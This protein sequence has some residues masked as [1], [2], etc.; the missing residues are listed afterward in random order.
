MVS[1][2]QAVLKIVRNGGTRTPKQIK[3]QWKYISK[4]DDIE[5]KRPESAHGATLAQGQWNEASRQWA[6]ATGRYAAGQQAPSNIDMTTHIVVSFPPG[7]NANNAEEAGREWAERMF[8]PLDHEDEMD[9]AALEPTNGQHAAPQNYNYITAF[10]TDREH[11]HLHVVVNRRGSDGGWLKISRRHPVM[12]YDNMRQQLVAAAANHNIALEAT[13]REERGI[14]DPAPT[15]AELRRRARVPIPIF[16]RD[17]TNRSVNDDSEGNLSYA[18]D[19]VVD[20]RDF[21][22]SEGDASVLSFGGSGG[23]GGNGGGAGGGA[24]SM[25]EDGSSSDGNGGA[26]QRRAAG[27]GAGGSGIAAGTAQGIPTE[28]TIQIG[29]NNADIQVDEEDDENNRKPAAKTPEDLEAARRHQP[30][31]VNIDEQFGD[32]GYFTGDDDYPE[33]AARMPQYIR[34]ATQDKQSEI[35]RRQARHEQ[36][37]ADA[38]RWRAE[39]ARPLNDNAA[40]DADG[41]EVSSGHGQAVETLGD[42]GAESGEAT[43]K[44]KSG[45]ALDLPNLMDVDNRQ[46]MF[47]REAQKLEQEMLKQGREQFEEELDQQQQDEDLRARESEQ[48]S[49][50]ALYASLEDLEQEAMQEML[51]L[52]A[53]LAAQSEQAGKDDAATRKRKGGY[54]LVGTGIA[55]A[56]D[57]RDQTAKLPQEQEAEDDYFAP[58]N[59]LPQEATGTASGHTQA[60]IETT[61]TQAGERDTTAGK[62]EGSAAEEG[63]LTAPADVGQE[64]LSPEAERERLTNIEE[65]LN[66]LKQELAAYEPDLDQ[67]QAHLGE[68]ARTMEQH[69]REHRDWEIKELEKEIA[70]LEAQEAQLIKEMAEQHPEQS[71]QQLEAL[72]FDDNLEQTAKLPQEQ[73]AEE[74]YLANVT[75]LPRHIRDAMIAEQAGIVQRPQGATGTA[76]GHGADASQTASGHT[77]AVIKTTE[78][79][80][81]ERDTTAGKRK[82]S[83][84]E[85]GLVAAPAD[86][87]Q[88]QLS[89]DSEQERLSDIEQ[90]LNALKEELAGYESELDQHQAHLGEIAQTMEQQRRE[91][92]DREIKELEKEIAELEEEVIQVKQEAYEQYLERSERGLEQFTFDDKPAAKRAKRGETAPETEETAAES[93]AGANT[94]NNQDKETNSS[95]Q[96]RNRPTEADTQAADNSSGANQNAQ[97]DESVQPPRRRQRIH[98]PEPTNV[99]PSEQRQEPQTQDEANTSQRT[100]AKDR[101]SDKERKKRADDRGGRG[102]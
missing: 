50:A 96:K 54:A 75:R 20:Y 66:A 51:D 40:Q 13:S 19:S 57:I 11:P 14:L 4:N 24:S 15:D 72:A 89:H 42:Q 7:T 27:Q 37:L 21:D 92:L 90:K 43:R 33:G 30:A 101:D 100:A 80:A 82:G 59:R 67:H 53:M 78:T 62:R 39:N 63:A 17:Q 84:A 34:K 64:Q 22:Q 81:S 12:N 45:D 85:E 98:E 46:A 29:N 26:G 28:I 31:N 32:D 10:H 88:E 102:S 69:R 61:E 9:D 6:E 73:E 87:G 93:Q 91:R 36:N 52:R 35:A 86:V 76:S 25:D 77:Q 71:D 95:D 65:K 8:R 2:P 49:D 56:D 74:D 79:Q 1:A 94:S 47:E 41:S 3:A 38:A 16:P 83:A 70:E 44:R 55:P 5:L 60:V 48:R 58:A 18:L 68:I 99:L 23:P 97:E